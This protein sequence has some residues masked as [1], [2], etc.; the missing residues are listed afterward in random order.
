LKILVF[1]AIEFDFRAAVFADEDAVAFLDFE[2]NPFA[3]V[4]G[5]ADAER[6]DEAFHRFFLGGIGNDD[7]ALFAIFFLFF[8]RFNED[9][10][11]YGSNV[12]CH[13]S[14]SFL[15]KINNCTSHY[16]ASRKT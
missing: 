6:D 3:I 15:F 1:L 9:P 5:F 11:A 4:V 2:R 8:D 14:F 13:I 16:A 10:I 7:S 12:Q